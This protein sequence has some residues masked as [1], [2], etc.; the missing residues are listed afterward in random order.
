MAGNGW[1]GSSGAMFPGLGPGFWLASS[2]FPHVM[3]PEPGISKVVSS[4][5]CLV[6]GLVW[7]QQLSISPSPFP[8]G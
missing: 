1:D 3:T 8:C 7:P 2:V 4:N 5:A 6:P